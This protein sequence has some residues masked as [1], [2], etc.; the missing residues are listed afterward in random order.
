MIKGIIFEVD[1]TTL[2]TLVDIQESVNITLKNAGFNELSLEKVRLSLGRGS[3]NLIKDSIPQD[4]SDEYIDELT[5]KYLDVYS[6]HYNVKTKPYEG[7]KELIN[8][9]EKRN[10]LLGIN[11]NKPN[12]YTIDLI[13]YHFINCRKRKIINILNNRCIYIIF[14]WKP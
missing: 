14:N 9:L 1:G 7:I 8:E 4:S 3:R 13:N 6:K 10:I 2:N 5:N 11:S 12:N